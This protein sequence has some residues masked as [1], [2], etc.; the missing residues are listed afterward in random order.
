MMNI[1]A[2]RFD[3][4][5][6]LCICGNGTYNATRRRNRGYFMNFNSPLAAGL[7]DL[8]IPLLNKQAVN[9]YQI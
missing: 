7:Y 8:F 2:N 6:N 4:L 9:L 5:K 3:A 1:S